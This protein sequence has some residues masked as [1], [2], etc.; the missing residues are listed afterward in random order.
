[1]IGNGNGNKNRRAKR[2]E[3]RTTGRDIP[4]PSTLPKHLK[5]YDINNDGVLSEEERIAFKKARTKKVK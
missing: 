5:P 4:L 3:V 1:M 2:V